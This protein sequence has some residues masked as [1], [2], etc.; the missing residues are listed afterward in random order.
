MFDFLAL[1]H[2]A[3]AFTVFLV[4][5]AVGFVFLLTA[6]LV[7]EPFGQRAEPVRKELDPEVPSFL[8]TRTLGVFV[9]V[10]GGTCA[11]AVQ[12][13]FEVVASCILGLLSGGFFATLVFLFVGFLYSQQASSDADGPWK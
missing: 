6:L 3:T 9:T 1:F 5:G 10:F 2:T 8:S 4:I 7:G 12:M 13:G 11:I